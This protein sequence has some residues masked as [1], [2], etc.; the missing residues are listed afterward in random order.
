MRRRRIDRNRENLYCLSRRSTSPASLFAVDDSRA[1]CSAAASARA[2]AL[3]MLSA[4]AIAITTMPIAAPIRSTHT[5][6]SSRG[7]QDAGRHSPPPSCRLD[8]RA[9]TPGMGVAA[10]RHLTNV[11]RERRLRC[12]LTRCDPQTMRH[13]RTTLARLRTRASA[14]RRE[15]DALRQVALADM[16]IASRIASARVAHQ[17]AHASHSLHSK[18]SSGRRRSTCGATMPM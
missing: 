7:G 8:S 17:L 9:A 18:K 10:Q 15:Y 2:A 6:Q 16:R 3:S 13:T 12:A 4:R 14:L 5:Y 1:C 11:S